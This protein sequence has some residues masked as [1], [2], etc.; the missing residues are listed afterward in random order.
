VKILL[1]IGI[2]VVPF[3]LLFFESLWGKFRLIL[4]IVAILSTMVFGMILSLA[5]YQ[6]ILDNKVLMTNIHAILLNPFFLI[7]V[8]YL[9]LYILY[10]LLIITKGEYEGLKNRTN[11]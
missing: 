8:S 3:L 7:T 6:V 2:L 9:G 4:N 11:F 5:V 10:R 1:V